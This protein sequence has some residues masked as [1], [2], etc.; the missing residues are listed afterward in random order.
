M[1]TLNNLTGRGHPVSPNFAP[2]FPKVEGFPKKDTGYLLLVKS[3]N[4]N[5]M[6]ETYDYRGLFIGYMGR[7]NIDDININAEKNEKTDD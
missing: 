7:K 2:P 4:P 1:P 6:F 3:E 5:F